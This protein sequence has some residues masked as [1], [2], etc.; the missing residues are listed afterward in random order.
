MAGRAITQ[1][2]V[3]LSPLRSRFCSR[4][5]HVELVV[6]GVAVGHVFVRILRISCVSIIP[7]MLHTLSFVTDIFLIP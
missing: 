4:P 5:V 3:C 1:V 6:D 7:L 2:V